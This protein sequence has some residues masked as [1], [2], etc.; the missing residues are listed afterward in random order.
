MNA[1]RAIRA[2]QGKTK[3]SQEGDHRLLAGILQ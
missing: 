2:L 1:L 3:M